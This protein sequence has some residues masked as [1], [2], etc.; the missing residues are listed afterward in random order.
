MT[1]LF[2]IDCAAGTGDL[3]T[4]V[5]SQAWPLH[6]HFHLLHAVEGRG[7]DAAEENAFSSAAF[8]LCERGFEVTRHQVRGN[9]KSVILDIASLVHP[10]IILMGSRR[11]NNFSRFLLGSV[12]TAVLRHAACDV[13]ILR[14]RPHEYRAERNYRLL[15]ATDGSDFSTRAAFSLASRPW[16]EGT[17]ALIISV[18]DLV[19]PPIISLV[20]PGEPGFPTY[21]EE[22]NAARDQA[23]SAAALAANIVRPVCTQLHEWI[24]VVIDSARQVILDEAERWDADCIFLGSHGRTGMDRFLL[25]ST[26]EAIATHARCS[27]I[28][29]R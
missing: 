19:S 9:A 7:P 18:V 10:N 16:P 13:G 15:L 11:S 20:G 12:S 8:A 5:L 28:V 22:Y 1:I 25:G 3:L 21:P 2:A 4:E 6:S 26:S 14:P 29:A 17:E 23:Q 24:P 27:V